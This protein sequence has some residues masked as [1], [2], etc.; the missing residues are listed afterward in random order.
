MD[1]QADLRLLF[2]YGINRFSHDSANLSVIKRAFGD[3]PSAAKAAIGTD[4]YGILQ[5]LSG[6]W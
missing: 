5:W 3:L 1:A 6:H 2:A 4:R